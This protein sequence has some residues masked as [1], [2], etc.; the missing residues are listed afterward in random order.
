MKKGPEW[1]LQKSIVTWFRWTH[2]DWLL[3]SCPMEA[4]YRNKLYFQE[5]GAMAGV[6]D[7]ICVT[8]QKVLFIELKSKTGR[9]SV[10]QKAFEEKIKS[11]GFE[12]HIIRSLD[13]FEN[14]IN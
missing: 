1:E 3:F 14:L 2:P 9:Q 6:S 11:L 7:L 5:T 4:T 13:E 8:P 12:Y 10:E